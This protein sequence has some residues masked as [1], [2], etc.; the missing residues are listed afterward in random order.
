VR[1]R[2]RAR[3]ARAAGMKGPARCSLCAAA[4]AHPGSL[5]FRALK[6]RAALMQAQLLERVLE[7][8]FLGWGLIVVVL[9]HRS[10]RPLLETEFA[11]YASLHRASRRCQARV[12]HRLRS[13]RRRPDRPAVPTP[14]Q[15]RRVRARPSRMLPRTHACPPNMAPYSLARPLPCRSTHRSIA[16]PTGVRLGSLTGFFSPDSCFDRP[17]VPHPPSAPSRPGSRITH[18]ARAPLVSLDYYVGL[19]AVVPSFAVFVDVKLDGPLLLFVSCS[20]AALHCA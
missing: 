4:A 17:A 13:P 3:A 5:G 18:A 7:V 12:T 1:R 8:M 6:Q 11:L 15:R 9:D 10:W 19:N 14:R 16:H 20:D 2:S